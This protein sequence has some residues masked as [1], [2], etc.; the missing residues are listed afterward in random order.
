MND[1]EGQVYHHPELDDDDKVRITDIFFEE[2]VPKLR[3]LDARLGNVNC[4]FAGEAYRD[5]TILFRSIGSDFEI[6]DFEYDEDG[7]GMD[8]DL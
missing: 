6:V 7:E 8:L 3:K 1:R 4:D 5:W 2:V